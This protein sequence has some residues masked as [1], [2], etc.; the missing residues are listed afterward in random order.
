M[1]LN[2]RIW[3]WCLLRK[4]KQFDVRDQIENTYYLYVRNSV[5]FSILF[6]V[7]SKL[8]SY[9]LNRRSQYTQHSQRR[10]L[11]FLQILWFI[12]VFLCVVCVYV[13][14]TRCHIEQ[15]SSFFS[16]SLLLYMQFLSSRFNIRFNCIMSL[17]EFHI[18]YCL[19]IQYCQATQK[20]T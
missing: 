16:S 8:S 20:Y 15:K 3:V 10:D 14:C 5:F 18:F 6:I 7:V 19:S 12:V 11:S 13:C 2:D 1:N 9:V 17:Y 4:F